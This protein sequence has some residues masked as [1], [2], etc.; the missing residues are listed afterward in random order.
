MELGFLPEVDLYFNI[1]IIYIIIILYY[2]TISHQQPK[3]KNHAFWS[4]EFVDI[5][6]Y[7]W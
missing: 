7:F 4:L 1:I 5:V 6:V 2:K 3:S